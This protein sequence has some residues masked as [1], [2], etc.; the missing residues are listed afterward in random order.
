V[1]ADDLR[2]LPPDVVTFLVEPEGTNAGERSAT[3][4]VESV[5]ARFRYELPP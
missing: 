4:T 1:P 3:L 2:A 5:Q